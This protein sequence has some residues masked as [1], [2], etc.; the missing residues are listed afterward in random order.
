[1]PE[2]VLATTKRQKLGSQVRRAQQA[3]TVDEM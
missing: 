3:N 1:M 2:F